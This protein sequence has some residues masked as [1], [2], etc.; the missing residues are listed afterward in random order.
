MK[1]AMSS[2]TGMGAWFVLRLLAE[3]H[4]VD[5]Y[6]SDEKYEDV[7][8]G[9]IPFPKKL[10]LDHRRTVIGYGYPSYKNYDLSLFDLTGRAKQADSSRLDAPTIGD[11]S[12]EHMLEDD[13]E[14]GIQ[15][16]ESCGIK[17]PPYKQFNNPGEAKAFIKK[18][19]KRYVYKPFTIGADMQDVATTY[20]A[21]DAEDMLKVIDQ[22]FSISKNAPFILQEF[23]K[24]TEA[25]VAGFFNGTSFYMLTCTLEE[26]KFMNDDKGPNTGC[27]GNLVFALSE[28]S[29][30]YK[31][32]LKK[33]IPM[34][35]SVGFVGMID[36]NTILTEGELYGLEWTPRF[37]YLADS[38][39]A[40]MYGARYG[41]M[42][43]R[44]ASGKAPEV[45]WTSPFG[46]SITLSI[47]PYPTEIR[48]PKAKNVP[49]EGINLKDIE[50]L[51]SMYLY[52]VML[53]KDRKNL[54]TSNNYGFIGAPIGIGDSVE[55]AAMKCD[56]MIEKIQIP[57]MQY[58]TDI[59]K[60]TLKRYQFLEINNWI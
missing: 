50:Q 20:V 39:I 59:T 46:V 24:G 48:I 35:Q 38:T 9:L 45:K 17:V 37:G 14:A 40:A 52:D 32:G 36:L 12:F 44:I 13:R 5:Y 8:S 25:S 7:L 56:R 2:Y 1:I 3:G 18:E 60:S 49:I 53:S 21:K 43:Q 23:I 54:I 31:N 27:A 33:V 28:D 22:L 10:S 34:L 42:L 41:D 58:R 26:K 30:I 4:D 16:M 29:S 55:E 57:N 6:L 15:A 11:G 19:D 51:Q 47:P